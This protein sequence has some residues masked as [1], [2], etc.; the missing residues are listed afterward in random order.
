MVNFMLRVGYMKNFSLIS[1][2]SLFLVGCSP[3][4]FGTKNPELII[5][6]VLSKADFDD[7]RIKGSIHI[8]FEDF[9]NKISSFDK[10]NEYVIY[11]ADFACMS[12]GFCG[13]L[14][15]KAGFE[16]VWI[17]EA[18]MVDW[19]QKGYPIEGAAKMDYLQGKNMR[20]DDE[21]GDI[22]EITA[23]QLKDKIQSFQSKE[24]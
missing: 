12:S 9:E 2:I 20:L 5:I 18:G 6:N 1:F 7:C 11:C 8:D 15:K 21:E 4:D 17:Y 24:K 19:Y 22:P 10:K 14:L 16:H 23:E 3:F 13:E